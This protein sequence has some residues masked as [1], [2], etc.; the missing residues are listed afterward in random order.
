M[1]KV[2]SAVYLFARGGTLRKLAIFNW[3]ID[4]I[5]REEEEEKEF[6]IKSVSISVSVGLVHR[7]AVVQRGGYLG[8]AYR[9]RSTPSP[10]RMR[11]WHRHECEREMDAEANNGEMVNSPEDFRTTY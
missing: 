3:F 7:P 9:G 6:S 1:E 2:A 10:T 8:C 11:D 4:S 5:F